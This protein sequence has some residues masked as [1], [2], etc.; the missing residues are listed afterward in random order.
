MLCNHRES[1][2]TSSRWVS[3]ETVILNPKIPLEIF[4][5]PP[6]FPNI[7]FIGTH[8]SDGFCTGVF[9]LRVHDWSVQLLAEILAPPREPGTDLRKHKDAKAMQNVLT[10]ENS[11][12]AVV[13]QP[14][15]WFNAYQLDTETFEG[16]NGDLLVHFHELD[17]DMWAA[18][19]QT[20]EQVHQEKRIWNVPME[21]TTYEQDVAAYWARMRK[22][23]ELLALAD[24]KMQDGDVKDARER[25]SWIRDYECDSESKMKAAIAW[26]ETVLGVHE[27][28]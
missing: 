20:L 23:R 5:P 11:R 24:E 1:L 25:L 15:I 2:L 9:F 16:K 6:D 14:R 18:M 7:H 22:S 17:G 26:L 4:L 10:A 12:Q 13:Y 3:P 8:D 19:A 28:G 21:K 27:S